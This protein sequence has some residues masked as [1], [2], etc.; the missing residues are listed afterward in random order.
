MTPQQS[1]AVDGS[2]TAGSRRKGVESP[3]HSNSPEP[4]ITRSSLSELDLSKIINNL[5]LRHDINFHPKLRFGP[6]VEGD[7]GRSKHDR[8]SHFWTA[9]RE[10][11]MEFTVDRPSFDEKHGTQDDW[12]LPKLLK[13]VKDIIKTLVPQRDRQFLDE[14][15]NVDLLMQQFYRG[16]AD[17]EKL[18]LW[19]SRVLKSYCAPMRDKLVDSMYNQLSNGNRNNDVDEL[20]DVA[21]HQ[22][23]CLRPALIEETTAFEQ[24]HLMEMLSNRKID[25]DDAKSWYRDA[26]R[27]YSGNGATSSSSFG[28]MG[29]FFEGLSRSVMP[30]AGG[31]PLPRTFFLDEDRLGQVRSDILD[32]INIGVCMRMYKDLERTTRFSKTP[33]FSNRASEDDPLMPPMTSQEFNFN[34]PPSHSRP[35]GLALGSTG[36]ASSSPR[37]SM[38][39]PSYIVPD[40][41]ESKTKA[42]NLRESLVAL[43][44]QAPHDH[45]HLDRWRAMAPSMALQIFRLT[46]APSEMLPQFEE[47][48][49]HNVCKIKSPMFQEIEEAYRIRLLAELSTRVRYFKSLSGVCLFSVATGTRVPNNNRGLDAGRDGDLDEAI[50]V[51]QQEGSIKDIAIRIAHVGVVHWRIWARIAYVGEDD[52]SMG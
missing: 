20:L 30:S 44:Q 8:A 51:G 26:A 35:S 24:K 17:L 28:D 34:T 19:L 2:L 45:H 5:Q 38:V 32:A 10:Q 48:L 49:T 27:T 23:R 40:M 9:L 47:K 16:I 50:R 3:A 22:I 1:P 15:F 31:E 37:S 43:L 11:L 33:A 7:K 52:M 13:A 18:A 29:I 6:N 42:R 12:C 36:S 21:N 39:L 41:N 25:I 46:N 4:P 14:G